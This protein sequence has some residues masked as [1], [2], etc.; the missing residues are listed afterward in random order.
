MAFIIY[1]KEPRKHTTNTL[2]TNHQAQQEEWKTQ[3]KGKVCTGHRPALG[4]HMCSMRPPAGQGL[5][6][7]RSDG[8]FAEQ[9]MSVSNSDGTPSDLAES[10]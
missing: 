9:K 10:R 5:P 7:Q 2:T 8:G 4:R 1:Q 6:L 3:I